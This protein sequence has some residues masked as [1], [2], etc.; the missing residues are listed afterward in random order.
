[1]PSSAAAIITAGGIGRRMGRQDP[2]QFLCLAG[3]PILV[4]TI[5]TFYQTRLFKE[6]V[7]VVPSSHRRKT[8]GMLKDYGLANTC[9]VVTGGASRQESVKAGL[10]SLAD[11]VDYVLVHDGVRPMISAAIIENCLAATRQTGAA[12]TAVAGKDTLKAAKDK[13]I[14][15][16]VDRSGLWRAQTP[17]GA[18][19]SL[20]R[21]AF[22]AAAAAQFDG[23]DEASLLELINCPVTIVAGSERNI[24]ITLPEDISMAEALLT[25]NNSLGADP[26]LRIG[27]GYDAHR[28]V[29]GRP[30]VLGGVK[31]D[32]P[33][34]LLGHSDADVLSHAFC[35][36]LLGAIGGGDIGRHFPD[37]DPEY[38]GADSLKL[39]SRVA[40]MLK[41][42]NGRLINA[43]ITVIAEEPKLAPFLEQMQA[44]L[45]EICQVAKSS[46]N[47]KA[48]TTEQMGFT[49]RREGIACHAVVLVNIRQ[50]SS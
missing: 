28:L 5:E 41:K 23:T 31:I 1:M 35:D 15:K 44:N 48:T 46:I 39:L 12:I 13:V 17:Q 47:L 50:R 14:E 4:H 20:L 21:E 9:R 29:E 18:K 37:S 11:S 34:G 24:K 6:I 25:G 36:A 40:A 49:G 8:F 22:R 45:A 16:T 32:H 43:D 2:K 27:H 42:Q 38:K 7:L 30:L 3:R 33:T 19:A 10:D 26:G